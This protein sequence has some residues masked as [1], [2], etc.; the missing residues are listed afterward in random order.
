MGET[1]KQF[2]KG[3]TPYLRGDA[4]P[5]YLRKASDAPLAAGIFGACIV[6]WVFCG[7]NIVRVMS[8]DK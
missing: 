3:S 7:Y 5:T 4:D 6:G 1:Q 8:D 2:Q